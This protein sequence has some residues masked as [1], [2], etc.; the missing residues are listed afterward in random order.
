M[1][2]WI[3][4]YSNKKFNILDPQP[5]EICIE[6][7]AHALSQQCRFTGHTKFH[8]SVAQH[9]YYCSTIVAPEFALEALLHDASEAYIGDMSR[10]MKHFTAAGEEY[11]KVE[12]KIEE[13]IARKFNLPTKMSEEV[14]RADNLMLYAEKTALMSRMEWDTKWS[15]TQE[16]ANVRIVEWSPNWAEDMFLCRFYGLSALRSNCYQCLNQ[17]L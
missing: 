16:A 2:A 8:Y 7:I 5:D 9:S 6:D 17:P 14:K 11:V 1:T 15:A 12:R 10:P 13:C 3:Q 4:T